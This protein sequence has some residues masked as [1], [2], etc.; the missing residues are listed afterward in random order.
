MN[1]H[2]GKN[3]GNLDDYIDDLGVRRDRV[4]VERPLP[5]AEQLWGGGVEDHLWRQ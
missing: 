1:Q 5:L 2:L 4:R 3:V